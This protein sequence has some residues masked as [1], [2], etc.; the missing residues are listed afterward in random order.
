MITPLHQ[1]ATVCVIS[2]RRYGDAIM[3]A[4]MMREASK[5]RPD[6][7]W[8]VWTKPEFSPLF[9]LM[10]FERIITSEFPI[11]GG[12]RK[13]IN[14]YGSSLMKA[15]IE[16]RRLH[17][18]ASIDFIGDLREACLGAL[19]SGKTH[20]SPT[21]GKDHWMRPL[22]FA[23]AMPLVK[24]IPI[25]SRD[26]QV[27]GFISSIFAPLL[28]APLLIEGENTKSSSLNINLN[29]AFHPYS[30]Q[31]FKEWPIENW[32]ILSQELYQNGVII[33]LICSQA[34]SQNAH[35]DFGQ[36]I[37]AIK[38]A[39]CDSIEKLITT[40]N[41]FDILI[42]VDSFL[43]HLASAMGKKSIILNAGNLPE[44]WKP[45]NAQAIGQSGG[46]SYY[47]CGNEP[48]CINTSFESACIKS[49]KP[50][51]VMLALQSSLSH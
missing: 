21:W 34:E 6:I 8:I 1:N 9:R 47:P 19:I 39:I 43:V 30:S 32:K 20:F 5:V 13:V 3:N 24:Y 38:I 4:R 18:D 28:G 26:A 49:I 33:T 22:I 15:V 12:A 40:L 25:E 45:P 27:Y 10:G 36:S 35:Q 16:L 42:G 41:Q 29:I 44:W 2:A 31:V 50:K 23:Q 7:S 14:E 17:I 51:Q 37:P 48:K 46:C 11:A